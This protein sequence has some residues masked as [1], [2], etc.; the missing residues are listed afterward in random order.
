MQKSIVKSYNI[1]DFHEWNQKG[2]LTLQPKFQRRPVWSKRAQSYL[3]DTILRGLPIPKLF[4]RQRID[5]PRSSS[6]REVVDGQQRLRA[7]FDYIKGDLKVSKIHNQQYCDLKFEELQDDVKKSFLEYEFSVDILMGASDREILDIFMRINSYGLTL[8]AQEKLNAEFFGAFKQFVYTLGLDH[9][10]FWRTNRILTEQKISRMA[11]AELTSELVIAML[12]GIKGGKK[13]IREFY[14]KFDEDFPQGEE[15]SKRFHEVI[16]LIAFV[17][18]NNLSATPFKRVPLFYSL[19]CV[20]YD[21]KYGLPN[22]DMGRIAINERTKNNIQKA[23]LELG[24]EIT[25]KEIKHGYNDF[26]LACRRSTDKLNERTIRH[27]FIWGII[28]A[29]VQASKQARPE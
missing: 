28:K 16:N 6:I 21:C 4:I 13:P 17:L 1:G 29:A 3:I 11:E 5:L 24:K 15:L 25:A 14:K 19:F 23:L 22:I 7:V 8:N 27:K 10:E 18:E 26:V 2:T 9:L 12:D 20:F